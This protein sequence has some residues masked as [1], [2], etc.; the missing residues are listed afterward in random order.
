MHGTE[1]SGGG[2]QNGQQIDIA[3]HAASAAIARAGRADPIT[4]ETSGQTGEMALRM[5]GIC[6]RFPGVNALED[7]GIT[8]GAG[9]VL[10]LVGENGAGKSTLMKILSGAYRPDAG[11]VEIF[12]QPVRYASPHLMMRMGVAIIYQE[13]LLA[14]DLSVAENIFMGRQPRTRLG[15][16][17]WQKMHKAARA[18]IERLGFD[19]DPGT[20]VQSLSVAHRQIVEIAKALTQN[21]R[22]IVL[23][24]PSAVLGDS[25]LE[26]LMQI[27]RLL[28]AD[29]VSFIYISHRLEEVFQI[30]DRTAVLRDGC[31]VG[32]AK[33]TELDANMLVKMMVGREISSIYPKRTP[34]IGA[35]I[36]RAQRLS[37]PNLNAVSI[38]AHRGEIVGVCGLAGAGRTELLRAIC[39]ADP[40]EADLLELDGKCVAWKA[41]L[42][43]G[44]GLLPEDRRDQGL[45]IDQSVAFN[46]TQAKLGTITK[47]GILSR[48]AERRTVTE[49]VE[50]LRIK[51]PGIDEKVANLSG[52]NQQKCVLAKLLNAQCRV[53]L[54]DEPTRGVDVGAKSEIYQVLADLA[55]REEI[56]IVMVSSELPEIIGLCDRAYVMRD[57]MVTGEFAGAEMSEENII[58]AATA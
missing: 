35:P 15:T 37:N 11:T 7:V 43:D 53:L 45:F 29:G 30:S 13:L 38:V 32:V 21:A 25:E 23:D 55:D 3:Q 49:F 18:A 50:R 8:L 24:E 1:V 5:E 19:I 34:K 12:G 41:A 42:A 56:A 6:K 2:R 51:T 10:A 52:G 46:I 44:V 36:L 28:S 54:I 26:K 47:R 58:R 4:H 22:I 57:G 39:G 14:G 31:M 40:V 48:A 20:K 27:I 9:E 17:D 33:T 16:V